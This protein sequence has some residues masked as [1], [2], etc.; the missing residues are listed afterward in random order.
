MKVHPDANSRL[1]WIASPERG[2]AAKGGGGV[3]PDDRPHASR[4]LGR[5]AAAG[6]SAEGEG[7]PGNFRSSA[8]RHDLRTPTGGRRR[9]GRLCR[10]KAMDCLVE[11]LAGNVRQARL[12]KNTRRPYT[13]PL[14]GAF[15]QPFADAHGP[16]VPHFGAAPLARGAFLPFRRKMVSVR[17]LPGGGDVP[18][19]STSPLGFGLASTSPP[20]VPHLSSRLTPA[21]RW[22][23]PLCPSPGPHPV[24]VPLPCSM[25]IYCSY[26]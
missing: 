24:N 23:R 12:R 13:P 22:G 19:V 2:G 16:S 3:Q 25:V 15:R 1:I 7:S 11:A 9:V 5:I 21:P 4:S 10:S 8:R 20:P 17:A 26:L 6:R 14:R 18:P